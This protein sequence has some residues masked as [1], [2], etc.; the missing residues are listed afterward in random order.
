[1]NVINDF[2]HPAYRFL[3]NF[4]PCE[5]K[6]DGFTYR[7]VEHAYQAA[8]TLDI[9]WRLKIAGLDKAG[10]AKRMGRRVPMR[11]DWDKVKLSIM[12]QLLK[13]KFSRPPLKSWLMKTQPNELVEGNDWGDRY[14][15][16]TQT[17]SG[18]WVGENWLGRLL[19]KVRDDLWLNNGKGE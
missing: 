19:M 15:G 13:E 11:S 17:V 10:A 4:Y 3:S 7:S 5:V 14:W 8:K 12:E 9:D 16:K 1:M 6:F 18:E 2:H